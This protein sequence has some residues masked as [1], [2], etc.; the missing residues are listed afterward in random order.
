MKRV[1][2]LFRK[3]I[4][5]VDLLGAFLVAGIVHSFFDGIQ[6]SAAKQ[7]FEVSISVLSIVF[8]IFFAALAILITAGDDDF[9]NFMEEN[10]N[11]TKII[12]TFKYTLSVLFVGLVFS[13]VLFISVLDHDLSITPNLIFPKN[14]LVLHSLVV[15]Y[16][17]LATFLSIYDAIKY[18]EFRA[19]FIN[20]TKEKRES[21]S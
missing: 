12:G 14:W 9:I 19:R 3:Y 7:I 10:K 20:I 1:Q 5:S 8:S 16:A 6:Y 18:A 2:R 11:Y 15:S 4:L 17:L 13:I 21:N